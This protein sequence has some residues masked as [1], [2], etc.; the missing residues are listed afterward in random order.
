[1]SYKKQIIQVTQSAVVQNG[2]F[3]HNLLMNPAPKT[4][5][6]SSYSGRFAAR[7]RELR[8]KAGLT[9]EQV[10]DS[11]NRNNKS[12]RNGATTNKVYDWE[13]G[14]SCPHPDLFPAIAKT[15][16]LKVREILPEK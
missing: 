5:D 16:E 6:V 4:I 14:R 11:I 15:F 9:V 3:H 13:S 1:L 7:L 2:Q 12:P 8:E 10:A